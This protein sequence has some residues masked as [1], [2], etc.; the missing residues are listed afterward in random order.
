MSRKATA[1]P[2]TSPS[3][4]AEARQLLSRLAEKLG[5]S[6]SAVLESA[7]REAS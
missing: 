4:G 1:S 7:I 2:A 3:I 5:L 6:P